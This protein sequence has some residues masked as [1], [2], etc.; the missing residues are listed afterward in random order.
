MNP[1][2]TIGH[3]D[4]EPEGFLALLHRHRIQAVADVRSSPYSRRFPH[5]SREALAAALKSEDIAYVFLGREL[6]ARREES[7]CYVDGQARYDRIARTPLFRQGLERVLEGCRR[8]TVALLC[9][10]RDPLECHRTI[11]I[12]RHLRNRELSIRHILPDALE[13]QA[14]AEQRLLARFSLNDGQGDLFAPCDPAA[15]IEQ[16][17]DRQGER[18]AYRQESP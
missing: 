6:G 1:L 16:A 13:T 3:S 8:F 2:Y 15:L 7:Q 18:I 4:H 14:E 9:A 11:L 17:Y 5:F 12:C 10:E